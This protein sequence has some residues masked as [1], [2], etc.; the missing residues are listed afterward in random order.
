MLESQP[1]SLYT[2][3]LIKGCWEKHVSK[4]PLKKPEPKKQVLRKL[5]RQRKMERKKSSPAACSSVF[6]SHVMEQQST[7]PAKRDIA[8]ARQRRVTQVV[9]E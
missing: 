7:I 2:P 8:D 6:E 9:W 4:H 1:G 3:A 5:G